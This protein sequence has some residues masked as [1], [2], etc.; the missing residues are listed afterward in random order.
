MAHLRLTSPRLARQFST[1]FANRYTYQQ[2]ARLMSSHSPSGDSPFTQER[3][4]YSLG[5]FDLTGYQVISN[6]SP[7][8]AEFLTIG[9][10]SDDQGHCSQ[11]DHSGLTTD[12]L[13]ETMLEYISKQ[14]P[15]VYFIMQKSGRIEGGRIE[16]GHL[17]S[18]IV[19]DHA[20]GQGNGVSLDHF[21]SFR[22]RIGGTLK[23]HAILADVRPAQARKSSEI[24][25]LEMKPIKEGEF[26]TWETELEKC[27][28]VLTGS[29]A[30]VH[31]I[32]VPL[33][34][35]QSSGETKVIYQTILANIR[36]IQRKRNSLYK[37]LNGILIIRSE[38]GHDK[39]HDRLWTG[40]QTRAYNCIT[41]VLNQ[42]GLKEDF[43]TLSK[44]SSDSDLVGFPKRNPSTQVA[45]FS[46][47]AHIME[48]NG[49]QDQCHQDAWFYDFYRHT[50]RLSADRFFRVPLA[51]IQD[52]QDNHSFLY[53]YSLT[54]LKK[55]RGLS[56]VPIEPD[57]RYDYL[58]PVLTTGSSGLT[59]KN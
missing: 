14:D 3:S 18:F 4:S 2:P 43:A 24:R 52:N 42:F 44:E 40:Y 30:E 8:S 59:N 38:Q 34:V 45:L 13:N 5:K 58:E 7:F 33:Q 50:L 36:R 19:S 39:K 21:I 16:P 11:Y 47:L 54:C 37:L 22:G 26:V 1:F 53:A 32:R 28:Q 41:P 10:S 57:D 46:L 15:S 35:F 31:L 12:N 20:S 55:G 25:A 51:E 27:L 48:S 6:S 23:D 17:A 9:L 29:S 49:T 56:R